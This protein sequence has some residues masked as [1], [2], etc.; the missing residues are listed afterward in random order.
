MRCTSAAVACCGCLSHGLQLCRKDVAFGYTKHWSSPSSLWQ[1]SP[2]PLPTRWPWNAKEKMQARFGTS[3]HCRFCRRRHHVSL[4]RIGEHPLSTGML[5]IFSSFLALLCTHY[6]LSSQGF[7]RGHILEGNS[8]Q[9]V[10]KDIRSPTTKLQM[11]TLRTITVNDL[12]EEISRK[13]D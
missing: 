11:T 12:P 6:A 13:Q 2:L 9:A 4:S 5:F 10:K 1:A 8:R 3:G 7:I